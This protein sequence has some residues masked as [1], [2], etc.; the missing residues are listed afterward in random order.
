M[1]KKF[2]WPRQEI[3]QNICKQ[4]EN[5]KIIIIGGSSTN[6]TFIR[7]STAVV[8]ERIHTSNKTRH[9]SEKGETTA[10][11]EFD[12]CRYKCF[13]ISKHI[14]CKSLFTFRISKINSIS[15]STVSTYSS[16]LVRIV[17]CA[18]G[19]GSGFFDENLLQSILHIQLVLHEANRIEPISMVC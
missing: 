19:K 18:R 9:S 16:L 1:K 15:M 10:L 2:C 17:Y 12:C 5:C 4:S 8:I 13:S 11:C 6:T 3:H 14:S 7:I